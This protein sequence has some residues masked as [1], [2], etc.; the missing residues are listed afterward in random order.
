MTPVTQKVRSLMFLLVNSDHV[1]YLRTLYAPRYTPKFN[2]KE[3]TLKVLGAV[4]DHFP[5]RKKTNDTGQ[6]PR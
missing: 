3:S 2:Y 1:L 5:A 4:L 6:T